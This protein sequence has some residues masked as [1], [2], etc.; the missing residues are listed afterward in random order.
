MAGERGNDVVIAHGSYLYMQDTTSGQIKT[1]V[2]PRTIQPGANE[3]P[4]VYKG[5]SIFEVVTDPRAAIQKSKVV[6]EGY[7]AVLVNP[8]ANEKHP[9]ENQFEPVPPPLKIGNK[10]VIQGP[11][12]FALWPGQEAEVIHGHQLH[13]NEYLLCR[14]YNEDEARENMKDAKVVTTGDTADDT[15]LA[16]D[17]ITVGKLF[18]IKGTDVS[19][20][21]PPT[22]ISVVKDKT[23]K[24][25]DN[26]YIRS[27][28]TLEQLEYCILLDENGN[29]RFER[30]P[31]VVFPEP[32]ESFMEVKKETKFSAIELNAIQGLHIKCTQAY[33]D[34]VLGRDIAE[35]EEFFITGKEYPIYYPRQEHAI[36]KYDG[37]DKQFAIA[38]PK[39]E[40]RYILKRQTGDVEMITGPAMLL[41]NPVT[42]V[43]I[44]RVLSQQECANWYPGNT[45]ALVF[46]QDLLELSSE[47]PT[48]RGGA[49]SDGELL[50]AGKRGRITA[51]AM[52]N[53]MESAAQHS[54][55]SQSYGA[56]AGDEIDRS[57]TYTTPRSITLNTKFQGVPRI[58]IWNGYAARVEDST[59]KCH[60]EV[61]PKVILLAYDEVLSI[62]QFSVKTPKISDNAIRTPYLRINNNQ[63][64]DQVWIE[65]ADHVRVSLIIS[66]LVSF[67]PSMKDS[68]FNVENYIKLMVDQTRSD[69]IGIGRTKTI[70]EFYDEPAAII[71][72]AILTE[73]DV[74]TGELVRRFSENG[75]VI[76][77]LELREIKFQ[78]ESVATILTTAQR[79]KI[80]ENV[81]LAQAT[82]TLEYQASILKLATAQKTTETT[83]AKEV[84]AQNALQLK[85][86][87]DLEEARLAAAGL[88]AQDQYKLLE[89]E[90]IHKKALQIA[91]EEIRDIEEKATLAREEAS[92]LASEL[93][94]TFEANLAKDLMSAEADA[95]TKRFSAVKDGFVEAMLYLGQSE[96]AGKIAAASSAT[97]FLGGT[98][99][100][101]ILDNLLRPYQNTGGMSTLRSLANKI[102]HQDSPDARS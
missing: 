55:V 70:K 96:T 78:D 7:Y 51:S 69:L 44:R 99:I 85:A 72:A 45:E 22:G 16:Q 56:S 17:Q 98:N 14:V 94:H 18:V 20:Y 4:V 66:Y 24:D 84:L 59:G 75:M 35:G 50:R 42:D 47:S 65:T 57:S 9:T 102:I 54:R 101:D 93:A 97:G 52:S 34:D 80:A 5:R 83:Q 28:M 71:K 63:V 3:W 81:Q 40:G 49:V 48:T 31:Q 90:R 10:I 29:K 58:A 95:V 53:S 8:A 61:G 12:M 13:S 11:A 1:G 76:N 39:G 15:I 6:P 41:P 38:I 32:T 74:E 64:T 25:S 100:Q 92:R 23:A 33:H 79:K 88:I 2:G 30:G 73:G 19:F 27:A 86:E 26:P 37:K 43:P 77:S 46:N 87:T 36:I 89:S 62:M 82:N 68:W 67:D 21:I 60:V 91:D